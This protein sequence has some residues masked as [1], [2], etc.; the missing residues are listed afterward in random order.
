MFVLL[1]SKW[2]CQP[3]KGLKIICNKESNKTISSVILDILARRVQQH[4]Q[5]LTVD[6]EN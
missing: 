2:V 6:I 1:P 3:N 5:D 4:G